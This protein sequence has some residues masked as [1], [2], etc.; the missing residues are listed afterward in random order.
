MADIKTTHKILIVILILFGLSALSKVKLFSKCV[1]RLKSKPA[2]RCTS[3]SSVQRTASPRTFTAQEMHEGMLKSALYTKPNSY[4]EDLNT[5]WMNEQV[6]A[7]QAPVVRTI[8]STRATQP[9][10]PLHIS[11]YPEQ[12]NS[13]NVIHIDDDTY[14]RALARA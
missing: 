12:M 7:R 3:T 14:A 9:M 4:K 1:N 10:S 11:Q 13:A 5:R 2:N 6:M 8:Q